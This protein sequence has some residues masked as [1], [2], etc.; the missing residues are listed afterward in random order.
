L[1]STGIP[2]EKIRIDKDRFKVLV[3]VPGAT[4]AE[5]LEILQRHSPA[6]VH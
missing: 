5:V 3:T 6:E 4:K 2:S 1:R